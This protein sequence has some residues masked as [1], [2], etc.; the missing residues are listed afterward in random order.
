MMFLSLELQN[1]SLYILINIQR[2]K[3]VVVETC[4]KYYILG[5]L[6]SSIILYGISLIYGFTGR[7]NLLDLALF[8]SEVSMT[9]V[10]FILG[11][12]FI[13]FGFFI[14]LG[15]AP[16][17]FW[18]PQIYEGAPNLI[19]LV[20]LTLPKFILFL[21]FLKLHTFVFGLFAPNFR[22]ILYF[23]IF[24]SFFFGSLGA[25]WQTNIKKFL[26][27]SAIT[28]S[29]FILFGFSLHTFEGL[30]SAIIYLVIY[31][32]S[33]CC[34]VYVFIIIRSRQENSISFLEFESFRSLKVVHPTLV[35][36]LVLNLLSMAG[37]PPLAGFLTKFFLFTAI[38]EEGTLGVAFL[39]V[40]VSLF[41][42]YYYIRPVK[43]LLFNP[44][45]TPA[46]LTELQPFGGLMLIF[47]TFLNLALLLTPKIIL[48]LVEIIQTTC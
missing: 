16:F 2:N 48:I 43:I 17:H 29:G 26:A 38:L 45:K 20:L 33:N 35:F 41:T 5:G 25:L 36:M 10:G 37:I 34:C 31:L 7:V 32:F 22:E 13:F 40:L 30:Y 21:V 12:S 8:C 1:F 11:L 47:I 28:N 6:S 42:A 9:H 44:S 23:N 18:V 24:L 4:I 27:Y 14:K 3:K 46:F 39:L 15:L 19:M